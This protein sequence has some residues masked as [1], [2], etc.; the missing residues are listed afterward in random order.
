VERYQ[1]L[2]R[3][4][5]VLLGEL[6]PDATVEMLLK[7]LRAITSAERGF[8]VVRDGERYVQRFDVDFDRSQ[9]SA[10]ERRFSRTLVKRAIAEG[11]V[12]AA[13][14]PSDDPV[15]AQAESMQLRG[16]MWVR[17]A[18]VVSAGETLAVLYL[19]RTSGPFAADVDELCAEV[20]ELAALLIR[21]ALER[22]ALARRNHDLERD[23]FAQN[24]FRGIVTRDPAML[25]LLRV[26]AQVADSDASV[27]VRGETGTGKELVARAVHMNSG[28]R[29]KP[30]VVVHCSALPATLLE[31]ELFGHV[32]GAFTGADRDRPGRLAQAHGGT[33]FL[34]EVAEI[35]PE[36]QAKLL[37]F[38]QFGELSR[39]G[40]DKLEKVDV[41]VLAATHQDLDALIR[42][43]RFRQDLYF[44]I[45]VIE[46]TVPPL[47]ERR[48]DLPLLA[49]AFLQQKW[50]RP[51][52]PPRLTARAER[53]LEGYAWPGNVRELEHTIE[54]A[55]LLASGTEIDVDGLGPELAAVASGAGSRFSRWDAEELAEAREA[56]VAEVERD[57]VR[58]LLERNGG[59]VSQAARESGVNR[60]YLQKLLAKLRS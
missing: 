58:G 57:F 51:G 9:L 5:R 13:Q 26:V 48:G 12:L 17:V 7:E 11:R 14:W 38:L 8:V 34:D 29:R 41:R 45:K 54:R 53:A 56:A 18:P 15:F 3:V 36:A 1:A 2:Y 25:A 59:N 44:R 21:R 46:L 47:R 33:L 35:P 22:D 31:S 16:P 49:A 40:S 42:E 6:E 10:D 50:R 24:D 4:A 43:R 39:A 30:F 32:R 19:E 60:T 28:R 20:G 23:L 55:C 27:L 52:A 37:R